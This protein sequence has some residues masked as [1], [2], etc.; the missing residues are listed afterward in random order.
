[1]Q[2]MSLI[3]VPY[4]NVDP[5]P[6]IIFMNNSEFVFLFQKRCFSPSLFTV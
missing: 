6:N 3:S 4:K 1:M 2:I 5:V